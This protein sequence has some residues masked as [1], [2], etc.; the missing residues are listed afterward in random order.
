MLVMLKACQANGIKRV[1]ITS[2][3]VAIYGM[4]KASAPDVFTEEHWSV[5]EQQ[6]T[7]YDR[8]KTLAERAAWDFVQAMPADERRSA[9]DSSD[10]MVGT[11][12]MPV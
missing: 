4:N 6:A 5:P 2:S 1:C 8:S 10:R 7:V 9:S 11:C 12:T 3:C